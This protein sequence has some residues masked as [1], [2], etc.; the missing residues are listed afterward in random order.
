MAVG[1]TTTAGC[2][3]IVA[4]R[5]SA[6]ALRALHTGV[7]TGEREAGVVVVKGGIGPIDHVVAGVAGLWEP[8]RNM[9]WHIPAQ[10]LRT[11]PIRRVARIAGGAAQAVV[12]RGMAL[13]AIGDHTGGSHLVI[14]GEG[15]TGR[16]VGPGSGRECRCGRVAVPAVYRREGCACR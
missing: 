5:R 13:V 3:Q 10:C 14:A 15:P 2:R 9:V 4:A 11:V 16:G 7:Q 1:V 8:G 12:V 6:V